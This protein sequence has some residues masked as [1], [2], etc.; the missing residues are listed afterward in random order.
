M[1]F[2]AVQLTVV[3]IIVIRV[4]SIMIVYFVFRSVFTEMYF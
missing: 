1:V 2:I 3:F 4:D